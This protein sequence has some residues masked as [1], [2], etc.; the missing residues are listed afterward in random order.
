MFAGGALSYLVLIPMIKYFGAALLEPLAPA[1][2]KLIADMAIEGKD[3]IQSTYVLY[4]GAG[5]V[6]AGGMISLAR[7]LPT[8]WHGLKS[9]LADFR[10]RRA[11]SRRLGVAR[12]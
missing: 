10:G 12:K 6:A 9:G 7:S 2:S 8:I 1:T 5:A 11:V 4:I 3:S